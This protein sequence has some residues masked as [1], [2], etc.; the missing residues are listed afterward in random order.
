MKGTGR[1]CANSCPDT[2]IIS[3]NNNIVNV[4]PPQAAE[5]TIQ[6]DTPSFSAFKAILQEKKKNALEIQRILSKYYQKIEKSNK[7][8]HIKAC[9]NYILTR[10]Y[11]D[12][13]H[14]NKLIHANFCKHPLCPMCEWRRCLRQA[15]A[16]NKALQMAEGKIYHLT[17]TYKNSETIS[18]ADLS[19]LRHNAVDFLKYYFNCNSYINSIEITYKNKGFHPHIHILMEI[20][21][22]LR[23]DFEAIKNLRESWGEYYPNEYG[24]C[25]A[26]LF[27]MSNPQ[28]AAAELSKYIIK[29]NDILSAQAVDEIAE[30]IH[31]FRKMSA[32]GNLK[33]L[34]KKGKEMIKIENDEEIERLKYFSYIEL[35]HYWKNGAYDTINK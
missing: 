15:P 34:I 1:M 5:K 29:S 18:R 16:I 9:G 12:P 19:K 11:N 33:D 10:H 20:G 13:S 25:L 17:L 30:A 23:T 27:P 14:T 35:W 7:A 32:A 24:Y 26:T 6:C 21:E 31:G 4:F 2:I 3:G 28:K 8:A 22:E